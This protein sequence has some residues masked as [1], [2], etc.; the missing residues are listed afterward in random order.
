[1]A[2]MPSFGLRVREI[3]P[4]EDNSTGIV[5]VETVVR[6]SPAA[7]VGLVPGVRVLAVGKTEVHSKADFDRAS[8]AFTPEQG[9]PLQVLTRD[10]RTAFVTVGGLGGGPR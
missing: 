4:G 5:E 7:R 6:G 8:A 1:M 3:P 10:G 9:L 2:A